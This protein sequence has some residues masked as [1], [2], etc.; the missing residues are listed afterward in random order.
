MEQMK[1]S[2]NKLEIAYFIVLGVLAAL[3]LLRCSTGYMMSDEAF[4][5]ATPYRFIQGDRLLYDEWFRTQLSALPLIPLL[6]G[7]LSL[8]GG[9]DGV[10]LFMRYTYTIVKV[11]FSLFIYFALE[12]FHKVGAMAASIVLMLFSGYGLMV[13]SYNTFATGGLIIAIL[14]L[15]QSGKSL[16]SDFLSVIGGIF[17]ALTIIGI[18]YYLVIYF[19]YAVAVLAYHIRVKSR[20]EEGLLND[21]MSVR[22]FIGITAGA[23]A[24]LIAFAIYLFGKVNLSQ[25]RSALPHILQDDVAH[26]DR[27]LWKIIPGYLKRV[28]LRN[29]GNYAT[30]C[31]MALTLLLLVVVVADRSQARKGVYLTIS[32][33]L[34]LALLATYA[35]HNGAANYVMF[36]PNILSIFVFL[37]VEDERIQRLFY[38]IWIPGMMSTVLE[39]AASNT[40]FNGISAASS[41]A[42]VGSIMMIAIA[43]DRCETKTSKVTL[44][45]FLTCLVLAVATYKYLFVFEDFGIRGYDDKIEYG[46]AMGLKVTND[47]QRHYDNIMND[48]LPYRQD[49]SN[50][51]ALY[52]G[53]KCLWLSGSQRVGAF[54]TWTDE[55]AESQTRLRDYY[56]VH[57]DK[58]PDFVYVEKGIDYAVVQQLADYYN[59]SIEEKSEGYIMLR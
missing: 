54:S 58:M 52:I 56:D 2:I 9:L 15:L 29:D 13:L 44:C 20:G 57:P 37:L 24:S 26:P 21:F 22:K 35:L 30:L 47:M 11:V 5:I 27:S 55:I 51:Y 49:E 53:D 48:T 39:Y 17:L 8:N 18:P 38:C 43:I 12:R 36:A 33:V 41:V 50:K 40:G 6:R 16:K 45:G 32:A 14:C 4:Y 19:V 31:L 1:K 7:F 3:M 23:V 28:M 46:P 10:I 59:T 25:L 34:G 42:T